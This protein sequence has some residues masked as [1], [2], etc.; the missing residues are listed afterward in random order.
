MESYV[1]LVVATALLVAIPGPNVAL[2]VSRSVLSGFAAG[3]AATLGTTLGVAIQLLLVVAGLAAIVDVAAHYLVMIKWLGVTY[4]VI[5]G[6]VTWRRPASEPRQTR[7]S[8]NF[9]Y[10]LT[11][12]TVNPKTLLFNAAFL[13]QFVTGGESFVSEMS[14][15]AALYLSVLFV[16][17]LLWA[18]FAH[19]AATYLSRWASVRNRVSGAFMIVAGIGLAAAR[20]SD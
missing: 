18:A 15:V 6:I 19:L 14:I 7:Q 20:R 4:L 3:A 5:L 1:A 16:G 9:F 2:I 17:D 10:G 8:T 11:L 12:A 13:P